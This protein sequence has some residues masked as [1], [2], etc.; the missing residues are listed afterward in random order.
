MIVNIYES[1]MTGLN[2]AIAYE[3]AKGTARVTTV[4]TDLSDDEKSS[5]NTIDMRQSELI[6]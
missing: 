5:Q 6:K 3:Q 4:S 1:I 2:E